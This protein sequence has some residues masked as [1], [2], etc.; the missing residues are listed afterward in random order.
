VGQAGIDI[1]ML[2]GSDHGWPTASK[3]TYESARAVAIT[4]YSTVFN[5]RPHVE[6]AQT[7]LFDD[8]HTGERFV[9]GAWS[10]A[11]GRHQYTDL[12]KEVLG[13]LRPA[14]SER[15]AQRGGRG[16]TS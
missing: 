4:T 14:L 7:L 8:A 2:V 15:A 9:V 1:V 6:P 3:V 10:V 11:I 5:V 16:L 13:I 12:C